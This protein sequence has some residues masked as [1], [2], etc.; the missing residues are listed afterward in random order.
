M[1]KLFIRTMGWPY[2]SVLQDSS[3]GRLFAL[4]GIRALAGQ[5]GTTCHGNSWIQRVKSF[6]GLIVVS[7]GLP[8]G[9]SLGV[10]L[11]KFGKGER[12]Q[13]RTFISSG[14]EKIVH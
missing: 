5:N 13:S 12:P 9:L 10:H 11:T 8:S 7:R 6:L 1:K 2:T 14:S 3:P 4:R